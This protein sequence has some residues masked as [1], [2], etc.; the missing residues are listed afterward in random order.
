MSGQK[1]AEWKLYLRGGIRSDDHE[2]GSMD[3]LGL[4][5]VLRIKVQSRLSV[6]CLAWPHMDSID[7]CFHQ[8]NKDTSNDH[9]RKSSGY[10]HRRGSGCGP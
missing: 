5:V 10:V 1:R 7:R 9:A 6:F 8:L 3:V 4:S 2:K